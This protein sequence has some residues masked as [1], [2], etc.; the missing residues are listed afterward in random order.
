LA[1][2]EIFSLYSTFN[3]GL[4]PGFGNPHPPEKPTRNRRGEVIHDRIEMGRPVSRGAKQIIPTLRKLYD[5][6]LELRAKS[7]CQRDKVRVHHR[8][9]RTAHHIHQ[10]LLG[11]AANIQ[12]RVQ[13]TAPPCLLQ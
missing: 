10:G 8:P 1:A 5:H 7:D 3:D 13:T 6:S 9:Q 4:A 12:Y 2:G 11:L